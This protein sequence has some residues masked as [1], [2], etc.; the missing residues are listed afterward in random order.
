MYCC[1]PLWGVS[2]ILL[3]SGMSLITTMPSSCS[4]KEPSTTES[5]SSELSS[6]S[7]SSA[8]DHNR[9]YPYC[10][11]HP[12]WLLLQCWATLPIWQTCSF[13]YNLLPLTMLHTVVSLLL[14]NYWCSSCFG[15][16]LIPTIILSTSRLGG[17]LECRQALF[18]LHTTLL[19]PMIPLTWQKMQ[20]LLIGTLAKKSNPADLLWIKILSESSWEQSISTKTLAYDYLPV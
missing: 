11:A 2:S 18:L 9:S 17:T 8:S 3:F 5:N 13:C 1:L 16:W 7:P 12:P 4:C 6:T 10:F 14:P 19:C 15:H 20:D